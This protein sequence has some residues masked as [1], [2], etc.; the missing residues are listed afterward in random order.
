MALAATNHPFQ[1]LATTSEIFVYLLHFCFIDCRFQWWTAFS[2]DYL[3]FNASS[4]WPVLLKVQWK[5]VLPCSILLWLDPT[6]HAMST[7]TPT[8]RVR[9]LL[10]LS[11]NSFLMK[12]GHYLQF[13]LWCARARVF[14]K[15]S[16]GILVYLCHKYSCA[17]L[18]HL[19]QLYEFPVTTNGLF[20]WNLF[21][22]YLNK[23][24]FPV[25]N[26]HHSFHYFLVVNRSIA[27]IFISQ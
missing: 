8:T 10:R 12:W 13:S 11:L 7:T 5:S 3:G 20:S 27:L 4:D 24:A 15:R 14:S 9:S 6:N 23:V 21:L 19:N 18:M 1:E 2:S 16:S 26:R 25:V 17:I 22:V